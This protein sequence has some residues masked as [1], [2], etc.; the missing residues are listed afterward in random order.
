[1]TK[2][3]LAY[4]VKDFAFERTTATAAPLGLDPASLFLENKTGLHM[5]VAKVKQ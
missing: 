4:T 5:K 2:V 3:A 1:V